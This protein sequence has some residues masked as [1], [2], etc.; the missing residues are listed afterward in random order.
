MLASRFP[1]S[2][3]LVVLGL[4]LSGCADEAIEPEFVPTISQAPEDPLAG[5]SV[6][7][8]PVYQVERCEAGKQMRC[9][10]YDVEAEAFV[11][12]P[13]PLLRRVF[14]YDRWYDL[15]SSPAGLTAE[16][17]FSGPM[18]STA[19]ESEWT[20]PENFSHWAGCG[21][22]SIW[23]GAA[24]VSDIFRYAQTGTEAD[25][26]RME[27]K[28]RT[29]LRNFEVTGIPGYLARY[30]FLLLPDGTPLGDEPILRH[31]DPESADP[32]DNPIESLDIEGLPAV[33]TSGVPDGS[34]GFVQGTP[35]WNGH[36]S[37][38]QYTGPMTAFPLVYNLLRDEELKADIVQHMTCY[39][40]R[41]RRLEI[42]NLKDNPD[43][44][45][46]LTEYFAGNNPK[47][48]PGDPDFM[49]LGRLVV[50]YNAGFN[51]ANADSF[52]RSCPE[53][54]AIEPTRVLDAAGENFM[55]EMIELAL[56]LDDS[57]NP[58]PGQI[59][60][61]YI[62]NVRGGDAS[63][64]MHL[65]AM[66]Y[67]FTGDEQY[68]TFLYDELI[69]NLQTVGVAKTMMAFRLPDWCFKSYGDHITYQTHWQFISMLGASE[70]KDAMIQ[71]M[72][73]EAWQKAL[74]NH[75]SAKFNV[76]YAAVVPDEV[77]GGRDQAIETALRQLDL[78][79][80]NDG[81]I[82]PALDAPRR[83]YS[84]DRAAV[85]DNLPTGITV[86]CPSES[87]RSACE[88][89]GSI[90]G[91]PLEQEIISYECDGRPGECLMNDGLCCEGIASE[92]L[93]PDLRRYGDFMW[94]R[95]PFDIGA[96]YAVE[97]RKQSP[98]R[99]L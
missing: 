68:R 22:A 18:P 88:Q 55:L 93:P 33:Y 34:G 96:A 71:V 13:D 53:T 89:G 37:I 99:D 24:L 43:I 78:F 25:Y 86:R 69:E 40:K 73:V 41:L 45:E 91:I 4:I 90:F 36:P 29:L 6:E 81:V 32:R 42:I 35:M 12:E 46:Q 76:M 98:G 10:I 63:H 79:G 75:H 51:R 23:T 48:D 1:L 47:F 16:R 14:L 74:Y 58:R 72:Q 50:Y 30:H 59:D 2:I 77:S 11:D 15:F 61:F 27:D 26:Q 21:D 28:V 49:D 62:A 83:T 54:M 52:D 66:A 64:L 95:S 31:G 3:W 85:I 70:L 39:L 65:A 20:A 87:E 38:D 82:N 94:Q 5:G 92:G 56:N 97:G 8:C 60:H 19:P 17:V 84:V 9:E 80:G 67:V 7:G 44:R 57:D